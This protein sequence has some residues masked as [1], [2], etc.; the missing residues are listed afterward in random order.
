MQV[1]YSNKDYME[2]VKDILENKNNLD[3][4]IKIICSR[5]MVYETE[6]LSVASA[7]ALRDLNAL[8]I[9]ITK[10]NFMT[11]NKGDECNERDS[12]ISDNNINTS[13]DDDVFLQP[14]E[15]HSKGLEEVIPKCEAGSIE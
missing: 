11:Y 4:M 6:Q 2:V 9:Q 10:I 14:V 8:T 12:N 1:L 7:Q 5:D 13:S 15:I 3:D